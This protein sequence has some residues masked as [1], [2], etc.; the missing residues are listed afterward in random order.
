M[1]LTS[2]GFQVVASNIKVCAV[3]VL[4]GSQQTVKGI[5]EVAIDPGAVNQVLEGDGT[6]L[7]IAAK[8]SG[9]A[10]LNFGNAVMDE[11]LWASLQGD[12]APALT[13]STPNMVLT[14]NLKD[15]HTYPEFA[16]EF[17]IYVNAALDSSVTVAAPVERHFKLPH[18]VLTK[19]PALKASGMADGKLLDVGNVTA[20]AWSDPSTHVLMIVTDYQTITAITL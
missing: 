4:G 1:A 12:T 20:Q 3:K 17:V 2:I 6:T 11:S 7:Y 16:I 9:K 18:C 13:G 5:Q 10:D 14:T 19:S 8:N 15:D